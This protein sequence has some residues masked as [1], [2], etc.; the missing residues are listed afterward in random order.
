MAKNKN[1]FKDSWTLIS[2][3]VKVLKKLFYGGS[4]F[5][6]NRNF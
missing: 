6:D 5:F 1:Y 4:E 3:L 2:F